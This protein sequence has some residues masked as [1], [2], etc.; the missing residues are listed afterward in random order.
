VKGRLEGV[1]FRANIVRYLGEWRLYLNTAMRAAAHEL[2]A[3]HRRE[4]LNYLNSLKTDESLE[5]NIRRA[6]AESLS[7]RRRYRASR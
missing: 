1:A 4:I 2:A 5:R 6:I 3:S 7:G